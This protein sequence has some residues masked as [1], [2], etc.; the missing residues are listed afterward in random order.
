MD[1]SIFSNASSEVKGIV[2][3]F[4]AVGGFLLLFGLDVPV[5]PFLLKDA[6]LLDGDGIFIKDNVI[7]GVGFGS[8]Q[9]PGG[10]K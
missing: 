5:F 2:F 4:L 1:A 3:L 8:G 9:S 6:V 10:A 7:G